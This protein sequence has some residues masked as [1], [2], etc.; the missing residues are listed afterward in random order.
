MR[1]EE[2]DIGEEEDGDCGVEENCLI[3][4]VAN[5]IT[6][7]VNGVCAVGGWRLEFIL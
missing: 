4:Q 2:T 6:V 7:F 1:K 5:G 3:S